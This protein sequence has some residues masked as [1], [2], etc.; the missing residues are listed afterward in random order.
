MSC[1]RCPD[2]RLLFHATE[3]LETIGNS[4]PNYTFSY[5][6]T[7]STSR[8]HATVLNMKRKVTVETEQLVPTRAIRIRAKAGV[9]FGSMAG[10]TPDNMYKETLENT[11]LLIFKGSMSPDH[12][13]EHFYILDRIRRDIRIQRRIIFGR[14]IL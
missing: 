11:E 10:P 13:K 5:H 1:S 14:S 9:T 8:S 12:T 6:N 4:L 3:M 2:Y 7:Q